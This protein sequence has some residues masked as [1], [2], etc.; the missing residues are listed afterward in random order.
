MLLAFPGSSHFHP[1]LPAKSAPS[2]PRNHQKHRRTKKNNHPGERFPDFNRIKERK[3]FR[4]N[5]GIFPTLIA[6][7][8]TSACAG[9]WPRPPKTRWKTAIPPS[10]ELYAWKT[11]GS[12]RD[13]KSCRTSMGPRNLRRGSTA[14]TRSDIFPIYASMRLQ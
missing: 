14:R 12:L 9:P 3:P 6:Q 1:S 7:T 4:S 13:R 2:G 5:T 11:R 10:A 8:K